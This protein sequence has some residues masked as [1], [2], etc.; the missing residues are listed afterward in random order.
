MKS[1]IMV[2]VVLIVACTGS[3][4]QREQSQ[5]TYLEE[6]DKFILFVEDCTK[7][8][9][10]III[11]HKEASRAKRGYSLEDMRTAICR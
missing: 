1:L 3:E 4:E 9:R 10:R 11:P 7:Q 5:A 6:Y 8:Q 2:T